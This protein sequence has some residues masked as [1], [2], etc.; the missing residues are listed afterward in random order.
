MQ[1]TRDAA[2]IALPKLS[3]DLL[4]ALVNG[5]PE[6]V[7]IDALLKQVWPGLIVSPET[8][9]QR[10]KLLR[11][12]LGDDSKNPR[13]VLV[14]R[15][16]GFRLIPAPEK[17]AEPSLP[18]A[19]PAAEPRLSPVPRVGEERPVPAPA[20]PAAISE[21]RRSR[22]RGLILAVGGV[23]A[24]VAAAALSTRATRRST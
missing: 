22:S 15:G 18:V 8:V 19:E 4:V 9:S 17:L 5:A 7:T 14:V 11:D 6:V 20:V 23:L 13:Y 21:P 24:M 10:V 3:F 1:V 2:V 12:A 16:R